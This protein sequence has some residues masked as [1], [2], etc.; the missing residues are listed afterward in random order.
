MKTA[1]I[2]LLAAAAASAGCAT[3]VTPN[4]DARF[5]LSVREARAA[6]T[7]NPAPAAA[8]AQGLDGRAAREAMG[9]YQESFKSPPPVAN[10]IHIGNT[11]AGGR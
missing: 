9:R 6:Q 4:Y 1:S 2:L 3:S 5:G 8:P 7:L 11:E 10:V